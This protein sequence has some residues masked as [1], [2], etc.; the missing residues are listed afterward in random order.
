MNLKKFTLSLLMITSITIIPL[1]ISS[2]MISNQH[3][4]DII[5]FGQLEDYQSQ[6]NRF[7][8]FIKQDGC[9]PCDK[10]EVLID[11]IAEKDEVKVAALI[12]NQEDNSEIVREKLTIKATPTIIFYENGEEQERII[13]L[14]EKENLEKIIGEKQYEK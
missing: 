10:M 3:S 11:T 14:T 2:L 5:E 9:L 7:I 1:M 8:L 6:H 4:Y 13:G 12:I